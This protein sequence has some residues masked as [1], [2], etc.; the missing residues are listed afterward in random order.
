MGG[1][2]GTP[3]ERFERSY[4]PE[5]MS[6]CWLWLGCLD[7]K[8]YGQ[9]YHP[10]RNMVRAHTSAWEL[11]RGPRN[12]LHVLH[13]CDNPACVNPEHLHLGTH[14]DNMDEREERQRRAPPKGSKNGRALLTEAQVS[15]IKRDDRWPRFIAKD[16]GVSVH[17]IKNI[18]Y[19]FTWKHMP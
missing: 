15:A 3:L 8:G 12:G 11:Y 13:G 17:I 2:L 18:K 5:P 4:I 6:G 16:Y 9:F 19:G 10:P 14:Q 1:K 7:A